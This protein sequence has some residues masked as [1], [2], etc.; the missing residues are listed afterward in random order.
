VS[1]VLA[2]GQIEMNFTLFNN[3]PLEVQGYLSYK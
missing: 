2:G 3:S 1:D